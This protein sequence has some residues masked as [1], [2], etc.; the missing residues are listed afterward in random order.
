M[1]TPFPGMDPY[2]ERP[3]LWHNVHTQLIAGIARKLNPLL[4]PRYW[5]GIE[6]RAYLSSYHPDDLVGIPDVLILEGDRGP[7]RTATATNGFVPLVAELPMPEE[8]VE[9]FLEV[10]D[11]ASGDVITVIEILSPSNKV[12][13]EGRQ[14]YEEKRLEIL[15]SR[16]HLVEIDLL[17]TGKP[18]EMRLFAPQQGDYR[19]VVSRRHQRPRADVYLWSV[20]KP[21]PPFPIPLRKGEDEPIL[22]LNAMLHEL[23]DIL[24]FDM[25][26]DYSREPV[27]PLAAD[28]AQWA[29]DL[30]RAKGLRA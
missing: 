24:S 5:V 28:D 1:S 23:Y 15:K 8:V 17:R 29:A 3:G 16:T 26:I 7:V 27:P 14:V 4:R 6:E 20:R 2:L 11:T 22:D 12:G 13:R 9:R 10:R 25:A 19:I 21:M 30:L 18:M